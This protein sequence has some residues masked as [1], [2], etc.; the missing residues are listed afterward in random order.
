MEIKD[1]VL[2][3]LALSL[4][5]QKNTRLN[6]KVKKPDLGVREITPITL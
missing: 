6:L 5:D 3:R 1:L 4:I 2:I